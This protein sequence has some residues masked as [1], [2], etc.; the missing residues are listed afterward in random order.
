[1]EAFTG[2]RSQGGVPVTQGSGLKKEMPRHPVSPKGVLLIV[3]LELFKV[4]K[5]TNSNYDLFKVSKM[6][7]FNY[8]L[9]KVS[10]MTNFNYHHKNHP[11]TNIYVFFKIGVFFAWDIRGVSKVAALYTT[12]YTNGEFTPTFTI[13]QFFLFFYFQCLS[14]YMCGHNLTMKFPPDFHNYTALKW[15]VN[16]FS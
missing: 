3:F 5:M 10:K 12:H 15:L 9:F 11:A 4:C 14:G 6:T 1:M 13:F 2:L 8:D 16:S 7:N